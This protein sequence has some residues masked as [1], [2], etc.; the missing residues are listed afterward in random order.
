MSI[1]S[2]PMFFANYL[3]LLYIILD[4]L[5]FYKFYKKFYPESFINCFADSAANYFELRAFLA[6]SAYLLPSIEL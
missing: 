2:D 6:I 4:L 1:A 3:A 5:Y